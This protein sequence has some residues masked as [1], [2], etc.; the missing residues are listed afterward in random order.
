MHIQNLQWFLKTEAYFAV[1]SNQ[2]LFPW[3]VWGHGFS[4]GNNDPTQNRGLFCGHSKARILLSKTA[5]QKPR[6]IVRSSN[7]G[8]IRGGTWGWNLQKLNRF[9]FW[10]KWTQN[11]G[12]SAYEPQLLENFQVDSWG[13]GIKP[14]TSLVC[15]RFLSWFFPTL[16]RSCARSLSFALTPTHS[17]SHIVCFFC[18]WMFSALPLFSSI[19]NVFR[20]CTFWCGAYRLCVPPPFTWNC[21]QTH[22]TP[23][24]PHRKLPNGGSDWS[25]NIFTNKVCLEFSRNLRGKCNKHKIVGFSGFI[26]LRKRK[27][28]IFDRKKGTGLGK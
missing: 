15:D 7:R 8:W 10:W 13:R 19:Q 18:V 9:L 28:E 27:Y 22:L 3:H 4:R 2:S 25:S 17:L 1:I 12:Q 21:Q 16:S 6:L 20:L 26:L 14:F 11:S 5:K 24:A 23:T